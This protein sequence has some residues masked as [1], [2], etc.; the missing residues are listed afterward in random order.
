MIKITVLLENNSFQPQYK[1]S[2]GLSILIEYEN[3]NI[4]LDT[5]PDDRY[6]TNAALKNIDLTKVKYLFL[7]HNH[8]DHTGGLNNFIEMNNSADIYIMDNI[9]NK[10]YAKVLFFHKSIGTKLN[11]SYLSRITQ[12]ENDSIID[13]K[14]HFIKNTVSEYKKPTFNNKLFKEKDGKKVNDTFDHEGILVFEDNNELLIFNSCSHNGILNAIETVKKKIPDKKIRSYIGGLHLFNPV[15]KINDSDEYLDYL[16]NRLKDMDIIIYTGHCTGKY[17][18]NYMKNK[19]GNK[20]QE[21]N[22]GMELF[23]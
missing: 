5:G 19:L 2:H 11:K 21:I 16:I 3:R 12:I 9:N 22:T 14:I 10:Y 23:V 6:L 13:N 17:A 8:D 4:L 20:I 18:L 1:S 15:S 7:S